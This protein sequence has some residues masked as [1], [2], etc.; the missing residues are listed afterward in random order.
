M[1]HIIGNKGVP[2]LLPHYLNLG[3]KLLSFNMDKSF[4]GVMDGL[5][6]V[7]L[8]KSDIKT[9]EPYMGR[10]DAEDY[11]AYHRMRASQAQAVSG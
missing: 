4:S 3:G 6:V 9:L 7:D 11:L 2:V 8:L 1:N 10:Q 5:T